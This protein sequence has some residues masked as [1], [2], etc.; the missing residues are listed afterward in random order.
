MEH[1]ERMANIGVPV[2][3]SIGQVTVKELG[4]KHI[5]K[6][7]GKLAKV[8]QKFTAFESEDGMEQ[9]G[10]ALADDE[11]ADVIFELGAAMT[12]REKEELENLGTV[13]ALKLVEVIKDV[14]DWG[15]LGKLFT[16][17]MGSLGTPETNS[18]AS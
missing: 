4:I 15:E 12:G 2:D 7:A 3:L 18:M 17:M 6:L 8:V 5:M 9:L 14:M 16:R 13:D 11:I 10:L 1:S